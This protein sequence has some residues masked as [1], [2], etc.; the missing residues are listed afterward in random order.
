MCF[1]ETGITDFYTDMT[2][3]N[4]R[5]DGQNARPVIDGNHGVD[6]IAHEIVDDL[7]KLH[8]IP[9]DGRYRPIEGGPDRDVGTFKIRLQETKNLF[10]CIIDQNV[11]KSWLRV[12]RQGPKTSDD[13]AG[14]S[15]LFNDAQRGL[16]SFTR[17]GRIPCEPP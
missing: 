13:I 10:D 2:V 8:S 11:G 1:A 17:F 14:S 3:G 16:T 9:L 12:A 5:R 4:P 15:S 7:L 6:C